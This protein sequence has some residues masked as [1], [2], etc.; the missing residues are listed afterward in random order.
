VAV[1]AFKVAE[2]EITAAP[3]AVAAALAHPG[4]GIMQ[5][6]MALGMRLAAELEKAA[7]VAAV[8]G[9]SAATL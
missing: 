8:R 5:V 3:A 1:A 9:L 2:L 7:A 6:Q 4:R